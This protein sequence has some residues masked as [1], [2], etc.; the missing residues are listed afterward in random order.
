MVVSSLCGTKE[1]Y[2]GDS[3]RMRGYGYDYL[4][5]PKRQWASKMKIF[6]GSNSQA[7]QESF[8]LNML[9]EKKKGFYVEIGSNDPIAMNNTNLLE[10]E[11]GWSGVGFEIVPDL[12]EKYNSVRKNKTICTDATVFDYESY[13][14]ENKF[15]KQIDYLQVDIDP[16]SNS[17]DAL[18]R[19]PLN[20]YRFSV[21]TFEHD[22]YVH[23]SNSLVKR[24]AQALLKSHGYVLVFEDVDDGSGVRPFEDWWIDPLVVEDWE[25]KVLD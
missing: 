8:V 13:F 11:Y 22:I 7:N 24:Q 21:I 23:A 16:A 2:G 10:T 3:Q 18:K 25:K 5:S 19:L 4:P 17:L 1:N 14:K 9:D 15:P 12:V 6:K 20:D